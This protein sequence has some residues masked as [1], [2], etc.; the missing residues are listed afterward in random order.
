MRTT[1]SSPRSPERKSRSFPPQNCPAAVFCLLLNHWWCGLSFLTSDLRELLSITDTG[2][3][4][5]RI[6]EVLYLPL[7]WPYCVIATRMHPVSSLHPHLRQASFLRAVLRLWIRFY[8]LRI[9]FWGMRYISLSGGHL[10]SCLDGGV[11]PVACEDCTRGSPK[12]RVSIVN[13]K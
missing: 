7:R 4:L 8:G 1:I 9:F 6:S 10:L 13:V 12:F 5:S 2:S 11:C 3:T